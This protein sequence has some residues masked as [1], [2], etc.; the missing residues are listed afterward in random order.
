MQSLL[1]APRTVSAETLATFGAQVEAVLRRS[2]VRSQTT[3]AARF[4]FDNGILA[5]LSALPPDARD[6]DIE[7]LFYY[8]TESLQL[9]SDETDVDQV[10]HT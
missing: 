8:M 3:K 2:I 7:D 4:K 5:S 1:I 9:P 10:S 6:E